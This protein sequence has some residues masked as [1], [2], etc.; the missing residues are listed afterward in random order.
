MHEFLE[1]L[2]EPWFFLGFGYLITISIETPILC[3]ALSPQHPQSRRLLAGVWLTA[4]TYPIII[5]VLP[6]F[7]ASNDGDLIFTTTED[8]LVYLLIAESIAHFGECLLFWLAFRPL[9]YFWR[10]MAAVFGANAASFG[11]G[12]LMNYVILQY[13]QQS[14]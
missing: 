7:F 4:C 6:R 11:L 12:L 2:R 10:D 8:Y 14:S 5:L 3:L 9:T 1:R 13:L